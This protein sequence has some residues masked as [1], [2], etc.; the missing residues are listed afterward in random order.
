MNNDFLSCL[1]QIL[2]VS[3]GARLDPKRFSAKAIYR[4]QGDKGAMPETQK[5]K[6]KGRPKKSS[7]ELLILVPLGDNT[8]SAAPGS[9]NQ[10]RAMAISVAYIYPIL[11]LDYVSYIG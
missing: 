6:T 4:D 1:G 10:C 5:K 8:R 2:R 7:A 3:G 9:L 11:A